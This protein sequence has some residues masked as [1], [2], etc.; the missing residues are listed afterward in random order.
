MMEKKKTVTLLPPSLRSNQVYVV[1]YVHH[2][3]LCE[4]EG[5]QAV[6]NFKRS[7]TDPIQL[8][9]SEEQ[10]SNR[11]LGGSSPPLAKF[12]HF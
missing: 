7:R 4:E 12:T 11:G 3:L 1:V 10:R 8:R 2:S 9:R 5:G 6:A